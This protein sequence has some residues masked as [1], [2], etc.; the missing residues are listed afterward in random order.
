MTPSLVFSSLDLA[1]D[2]KEQLQVG[3]DQLLTLV[4]ETVV[5]TAPWPTLTLVT[6]GAESQPEQGALWGLSRTIELEYPELKCRRIDLDP[7]KSQEEQE[8]LLAREIA[9]GS[10]GGVRFR[11][12]RRFV[13]RLQ[14]VSSL[15]SL[16]KSSAESH[17]LKMDGG[18]ERRLQLVALSLIHI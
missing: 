6:Q 17:E 14:R 11:N 3:V 7:V 16:R 13:A 15:T 2:W 1:G 12:G 4:Q 9:S 5:K 8:S 18:E 10:R